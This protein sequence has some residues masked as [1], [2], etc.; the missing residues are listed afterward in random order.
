MITQPSL[1]HITLHLTQGYNRFLR[2]KIRKH[3]NVVIYVRCLS[4]VNSEDRIC[5]TKINIFRTFN[6]LWKN[7]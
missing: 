6:R 7:V 1:D 4:C 5:P 3:H 2:E